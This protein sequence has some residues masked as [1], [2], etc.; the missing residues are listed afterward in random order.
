MLKKKHVIKKSRNSKVTEKY[1]INEK[2]HLVTKEILYFIDKQ[3]VLMRPG[4]C[5][6]VCVCVGRGG[7]EGG[8]EK[9]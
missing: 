2:A 4:V 7:V 3:G 6:C 8:S 1:Y 5:V 9:N